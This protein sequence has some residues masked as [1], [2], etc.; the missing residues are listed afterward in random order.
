MGD[1]RQASGIERQPRRRMRCVAIATEQP[2]FVLCAHVT[3]G[4]SAVAQCCIVFESFRV[5]L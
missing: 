4:K 1:G 3:D 2:N 5:R